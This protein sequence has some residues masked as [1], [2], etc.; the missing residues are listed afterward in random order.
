[1]RT[2]TLLILGVLLVLT[3]GV[4]AAQSRP[5]VL[6]ATTVLDGNGQ[7]LRNTI[8]VIE[9]S[10][11]ARIGGAAPAGAITYDLAG[12]TVS[13]GWID[14]HSHIVEHFYNGRWAGSEEPPASALL[15]V[16]DNA[17]VTLAAGFTTIQSPGKLQDRDLRDAI[18]R[19]T[20]PGPRILTSLE[21]FYDSSGSPE[22]LRE[23]I[24]DRKRQGADFIKIYASKSI[25]EGGGPSMTEAQVQA[26][27][28]E[29]RAQGMRVMAH[30]H[31]VESAKMAILAGCNSIEHGA[32]L[33]DEVFD[34]MAQRGTYYAPHI[35]LIF[36]NYLENKQKYLGIGNY[37][38]EGF[39]F[40]E[41]ATDIVVETFK[42]ALKHKD[43][44]IVFGT[45]AFAGGHGRNAEELFYR[46]LDGGQDPMAAMVSATSVSAESIHMQNRIGSITAGMEADIIAMDG[47]PLRDASAVRRVLFVMKGGK[48]FE[49][50]ARGSKTALPAR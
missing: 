3:P 35:G 23:A 43:L 42:R 4:A 34:L 44:K 12:M 5:I 15:N 17:V 36:R 24:R 45:D 22:T 32:Y 47:D 46:I 21:P 27:C 16:V 19:G 18:A 28:G 26:A 50:L 2:A 48:V 38:E 37:N 11:I 29:G 14:T 39:A 10:K 41:K 7:I 8:I 30:A 1:M 49:N 40:M 33:T 9:G 25:R 20:L 31:S 6:K 13:P